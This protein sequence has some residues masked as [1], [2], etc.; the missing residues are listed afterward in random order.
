[1]KRLDYVGSLVVFAFT[2]NPLLYACL[3]LSLASAAIEIAAMTVLMPLAA[4]MAGETA[5]EAQVSAWLHAA[6]LQQNSGSLLIVFLLLL[7]LRLVTQFMSQSMII[8]LG[9]RLLLQMTTRAFS[10]LM[11]KVPVKVIEQKSIGYFITL[12]GDEAS[13]AT[14]VIVSLAQFVTAITLGGLYF[15]AIVSYSRAVAIA[16]TLFMLVTFLSLFGSFRYSHRLGIKQVE[17]SQTAGSLFLD[18]LNGLRSVRSFG[19][20]RFVTDSYFEQIRNYVRTLALI[21]LVSLS[22]RLLPALFLVMVVALMLAIPTSTNFFA[23]SLPTIATIAILLMRFFPIVG[24]G[25]GLM[26]RVVS[27]A[28]SG[29]DVTR[30]IKEFE[31]ISYPSAG[32]KAVAEPIRQ[33]AIQ[34]VHF[35]HVVGKP[36]LSGFSCVLKSGKSYAIVG[37]SGSGKSTLLDLILGFYLPTRGHI[38]INGKK[39]IDDSARL[40]MGRVVLV[41]QETAIFN[42]TLGN[43]LKLGFEASLP[44]LARASSVACAD[45]FIDALPERYDTLLQYRGTNFSGGQKQ[46]IG[47]ARAVLRHP[48]VLLLDESTSALDAAMRQEVVANLCR[49]FS[50]RILVFVTHDPKVMSAV[51]EVIDLD[52]AQSRAT[53]ISAVVP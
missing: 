26:L 17:Q 14:T 2:N 10:A 4:M 36:V 12:A 5:P 51:D 35:E 49:E 32:V 11:W 31:T 13:R 30:I 19:A 15:L 44:A 7:A 50:D 38:E 20:E 40:R 24:Q 42:D 23:V 45:E 3:I 9:R 25:L 37:R 34:D 21:D 41:S 29:Q 33:L 52:G 16:V 6:G 8:Y 18:S 46:R 47:I 48:D 39:V 43:N 1:M 53:A 28:Q 22:A 27:D